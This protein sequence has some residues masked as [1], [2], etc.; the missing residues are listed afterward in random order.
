MRRKEIGLG[1]VACMLLA[2][3]TTSNGHAQEIDDPAALRQPLPRNDCPTLEELGYRLKS[4]RAI[5]LDI[6]LM[7]EELPPDCATELF[8]PPTGQPT[9]VVAPSVMV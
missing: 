6:A 2:A 8:H 7:G 3:T 9:S 4:V 5:Q 1:L